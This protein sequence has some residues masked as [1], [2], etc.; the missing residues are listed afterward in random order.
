MSGQATG[1]VL[2]HGPRNRAMRAVLLPIADAANADGLH[3]HPGIAAIVEGS[4]YSRR[5][6]LATITKLLEEGWVA[7]EEQGGGRGKATVYG[8]PW[9][10]EHPNGNSAVTAPPTPTE[11]VQS[12]HVKGAV[13]ARKGAVPSPPTS[14]DA[15]PTVCSTSTTNNPVA[16][17][18]AEVLAAAFMEPLPNVGPLFDEFWQAWPRRNGKRLGRRDAERLWA[19]LTP[20]ER[21]L[22]LTG[23]RHYAT[24]SDAGL[25]GAMDAHRWLRAAGWTDWQT[26]A[27][28]DPHRQ[29]RGQP[30]ARPNP[31]ARQQVMTDR[32]QPSGRWTPPRG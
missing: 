19:R 21:D 4:L 27:V 10:R 24:A 6:V 16:R 30:P 13:S 7:I 1:W 29:A 9:V 23:A 26:P 2:R 22:A 8:I 11:T 15:A 17:P 12:Q 28:A 32:T 3:S 31:D 20:A 18:A 5:Q 14:T 25:A